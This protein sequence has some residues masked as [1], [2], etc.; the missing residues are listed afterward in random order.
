MSVIV[1]LELHT[2]SHLHTHLNTE[3]QHQVE[4][5][6]GANSS[7]PNIRLMPSAMDLVKIPQ[8]CQQAA[9]HHRY[10]TIFADHDNCTDFADDTI[11]YSGTDFAEK[12]A[13][14]PTGN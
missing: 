8:G 13:G 9:A 6:R 2:T 5:R 1:P 3:I 11:G 14:L 7:A 4:E 10:L 12:K